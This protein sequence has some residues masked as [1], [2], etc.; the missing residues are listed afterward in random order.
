MRTVKE[1]SKLTGIS[2][3]T[4][5]WYDEIGLL[6]PTDTSEAGYRLYDDKALEILQ[7]IL[8]FRE[9]DMPLKEI[10]A[11][12]EDPGFDKTE[13]L[14][15]QKKMLEVKRNRLNRLIN[16][17]DDILRGDNKMD[18]TVF[19][20][21]E[22]DDMYRSMESN[23][24][25]EQKQLFIEQYGS[26]EEFE[27]FF[28]ESASSEAAQKNF[29][30]VV[31]WYGSKED[32]L[33]ASK[34]PGNAELFPSHQKRMDEILQKL[35]Q[36]KEEDVNSFE[37]KKMIGEYEFV[38]KQMFQMDDVKEMMLELAEAYLTNEQMKKVQ[39]SIYGEGFAVFLGQALKAYFEK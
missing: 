1:V 38:S 17:I 23:M 25:E 34:N 31:E 19:N 14:K 22:I 6:K 33:E 21:E 27:K 32:A 12:M 24:T 2:V 11:I 29:Q 15:S 30:K 10:K 3:R 39:D 28:K 4:L 13:T 7:Q 9:F 37:I 20:K 5:H 26:M 35:A 16:S 8:F 36:S 18:F